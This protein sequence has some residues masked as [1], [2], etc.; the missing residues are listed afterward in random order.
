MVSDVP[1]GSCFSAGLD[2]SLI[3]AMASKLNNHNLI[4]SALFS[5]A[6]ILGGILYGM[7]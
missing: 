1:I 2:S 4:K 6:T 7:R 5:G 3:S